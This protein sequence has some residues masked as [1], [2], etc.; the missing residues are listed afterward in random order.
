MTNSSAVTDAVTFFMGY[1][2]LRIAHSIV[3][4]KGQIG[5]FGNQSWVSKSLKAAP[6]G[7]AF[8]VSR[9]EL[10]LEKSLLKGCNLLVD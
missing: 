1:L 2:Y 9:S 6:G 3:A 7:A 10:L 5:H 8:S 4:I